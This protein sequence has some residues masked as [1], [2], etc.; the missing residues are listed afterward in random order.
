MLKLH[1][2][3]SRFKKKISGAQP[4][5][6]TP[7]RR[8]SIFLD[9]RLFSI[10][11]L[12]CWKYMAWH[13]DIQCILLLALQNRTLRAPPNWRHWSTFM[14]L[15]VLNFD[16]SSVKYTLQ[17]TENYCHQWLSDSSRVHH[18]RFRPGPHWESLLRSAEP[19]SRL[20]TGI[21]PLHTPT[22]KAP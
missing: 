16:Q 18:I 22:T 20:G 13:V 8:L 5:D 11:Q 19:P 14:L 17:S 3:H 2:S 1:L 6:P 10:N 12:I 7:A 21:P 4:P 9:P 15:V